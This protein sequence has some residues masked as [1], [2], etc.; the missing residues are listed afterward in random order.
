MQKSKK[1]NLYLPL[2][3]IL[4]GWLWTFR[5]GFFTAVEIWGISEI[6]NHCFL[7]LPCS[8]YFIYQKRHDL[9]QVNLKPNYWLLPILVGCLFL[10][11][12]GAIGDI[13]LFMHIATFTALPLLIWMLIGNQAAKVIMFPLAMILFAIPVG[14][15]LIPFL[16][17]LTTDMAVPL[18]ELTQVPVY[19]NGL[20]IDIPEGRF[21][22]A[23]ACSGISFLIASIVFGCIY[24]Y[25]SFTTFRKRMLFVVVSFAVPIF[26]NALRV[27]G[28]I[29]TGHL[30]NMEYA[31]GADH[32]IY[33][34]VFYGIIIFILVLIGE[35]F[36]DTPIKASKDSLASKALPVQTINAKL[37]CAVLVLFL[38]Q[39]LWLMKLTL[40][41]KDSPLYEK[42]NVSDD[43][44]VTKVNDWSPIFKGATWE[45]QGKIDTQAGSFDYY[46]ANY[47]SNRQGE[48]ISSVNV[49]YNNE[50]WILT[51]HYTH[52]M[53]ALNKHV[54]VSHIVSSAGNRRM[55][56]HWYAIQDQN[57][58]STIK[59]K[60]Y[61][62]GLKM[63]GVEGNNSVFALSFEISDDIAAPLE[64]MNN[65]IKD[66]HDQVIPLL[67]VTS[68]E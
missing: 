56:I 45:E 13:K 11:L 3:I 44:L 47:Q 54:V 20:Y 52:F 29:L 68:Y 61:E 26:A 23:E 62:T 63:F 34:G 41:E 53:L 25:I 5:E 66:Y 36:R 60:L 42:T 31:V 35:K 50:H 58:T 4:M 19:R 15:Q 28:I 18:L 40:S 55:I 6:F 59:A 64:F 32:L 9:A 57:F 65:F 51:D 8:L 43:V 21:L 67:A 39:Q 38:G 37:Y 1:I 22:V 17:E 49:L 48:L 33:G 2:V 24:A 46:I 27:Y 16:Q 12:F 14:E 30:S 10:Q 7:V